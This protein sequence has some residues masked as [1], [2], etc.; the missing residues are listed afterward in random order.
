MGLAVPKELFRNPKPGST[1]RNAIVRVD[2]VQE[3]GGDVVEDP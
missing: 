2:D 3:L 1:G